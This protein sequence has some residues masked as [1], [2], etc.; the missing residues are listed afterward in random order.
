MEKKLLA[1]R[2]HIRLHVGDIH[3]F[4][5]AHATPPGGHICSSIMS[6]EVTLCPFPVGIMRVD[7]DEEVYHRWGFFFSSF[8]LENYRLVVFVVDISTLILILLISDLCSWLFCKSFSFQLHPSISIY[9]ILFFWF[10][11]YSFDF[12]F[13]SLAL[14]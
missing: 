11:P 4:W 2:W 14:L 5:M 1:Y 7:G 3:A 13:F 9:D 6:L 8:P 12:N 10:D